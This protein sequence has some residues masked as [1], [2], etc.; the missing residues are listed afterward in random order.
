MMDKMRGKSEPVLELDLI[1]VIESPVQPP[2]RRPIDFMPARFRKWLRER[3]GWTSSPY[4]TW[5]LNNLGVRYLLYQLIQEIEDYK[6]AADRPLLHETHV[7]RKVKPEDL[8]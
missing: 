1:E 2:W 8:N 5:L 6:M 4:E 7:E 3:F